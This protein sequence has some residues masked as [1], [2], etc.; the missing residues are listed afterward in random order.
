MLY[1]PNHL[2]SFY[3]NPHIIMSPFLF[4]LEQVHSEAEREAVPENNLGL[5]FYT[6]DFAGLSFAYF[7]GPRGEQLELYR[8]RN[9]TRHFFGRDVCRRGGVATAYVDDYQDNEWKRAAGLTGKLFG[10]MQFGTRTDDLWR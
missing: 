9:Q 6:G 1:N 10:L 3:Y 2:P 4:H 5:T 8:L 7:K